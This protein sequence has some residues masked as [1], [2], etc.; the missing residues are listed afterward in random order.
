[1]ISNRLFSKISLCHLI[2]LI[3]FCFQPLL[4]KAQISNRIQLN[5]GKVTVNQSKM[6]K[7]SPVKI[8]KSD[9]Q[10]L[11]IEFAIPKFKV[12]KRT[13]NGT[14]FQIIKIP[15]FSQTSEAGKPQVPFKG[16]L[17]GIPPGT[18]AEAKILDF[19]SVIIPNYNIFPASK[20]VIKQ[21]IKKLLTDEDVN[22]EFCLDQSVY[23]NN[24]FYPHQIAKTGN[25]GFIRDQCVG[26]LQIF[27]IQFNPVTHEIRWY[28]RIKIKIS[29]IAINSN[30]K[31]PVSKI[32]VSKP[33]EKILSNSLL[34]YQA[35]KFWKR[36]SPPTHN[37]KSINRL[38]HSQIQSTWY[39]ILVEKNGIYIIDKAQLEEAGFNTSNIDPA[40]I[41]I[42][43]K[44]KEI[45]IYIKGQE[46]GV[47]DESD[48]I[49]FY[50][51]QTK[52]DYT[53]TNI[54]WLNIDETTNGLRMS[55]KDG[56]I[57]GTAPVLIRSK[58][59]IH[60]E[61]EN[62][63][64]SGI[65]NGE[66]VDHWFWDFIVAPD[67]LNF[68]ANLNNV[69]DVSNQN[70]SFK[71]EYQGFTD[72]EVS[73]DHHSILSLNGHQLL[74]DFWDGRIKFNSQTQF[75]Q[76]YLHNG[77]NTITVNLPG[78]TGADADVH[79]INWFEVEYWR[80]YIAHDDSS[81][82]WGEGSG[83]LRFEVK[84]FSNNNIEI[85]DITDITNIK[86][87]INFTV[88][89][90]DTSNTLIFQ[91]D[92]YNKQRYFALTENKR[93]VPSSIIADDPSQLQSVNN[94]ADYIIITHEDFYNYLIPLANFRQSKGLKVKIIKITDIYDEFNYGIKN[95][96][97]IKIFLNYAYCNWQKPAPTY[98]LLV[99]DATHDYKDHLKTGNK[100]YMPTHL[101]ESKEYN[102]ETS[103]D[104]WFVCVSGE[105]NLPDMLI[106][107]LSVRNESEAVT[108]VNKIIDYENNTP[109]NGWN[110]NALFIADN[111]D[112]K[113]DYGSHSDYLVENF[114]PAD[115]TACKA[116]LDD[117]L[118]ADSLKNKII[119]R[120]NQGCLIA[121]YFGHGGIEFW[122]NEK[123]L[124]S[125]DVAS[126]NNNRKL[127]FIVSLSCLNG[128][129][130]H[131]QIPYCLAEE[132][133]KA[134][135]GGAIA[136][137]SPSGFA[138]ISALQILGS[139]LF[140]SLFYNHNYTLGSI[141]ACSKIKIFSAGET[142]LDH[143]EFYNLL[144]DP[145]LRLSVIPELTI[146]PSA[147]YGN[148][149]V[150]DTLA[151]VGGV[152]SAWI[153][154]V[155]SPVNF[156]IRTPGKYGLMYINGD[157]PTTPQI[158]GGVNGDTVR[159]KLVTATQDTF[160]LTPTATWETGANHNLDLNVFTTSV[161][162]TSPISIEIQV[163]D[164]V[165]GEKILDSDPIPI[166]SIIT[167]T[168]EG[169]ENGI[170]RNKIKLLLNEQLINEDQYTYIHQEQDPLNNVVIV[171]EPQSLSYDEYE[172]IIRVSDLSPTPN[173]I[174]KHFSFKISSSLHLDRVL[175]FPNPMQNSTRFTYYLFNNEAA[176][177]NIKIYAVSG[178]LIKVINNAAGEVGYNETFWDGRDANNDE[179]ANGVYFYKITA[180]V[181]N[182]RTAVIER[183]V[184][185]K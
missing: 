47:F 83:Q 13:N 98:V 156:T 116:Y 133:L 165:V 109:E 73:P 108:I 153:N 138:N 172:M 141:V 178:R 75:P 126:L 171:Y 30:I 18:K 127:P 151:E 181:G 69:A 89:P 184:N 10:G 57:I 14:E 168:I 113:G 12:S 142:Y 48:Y 146:S 134:D 177:V 25:T 38:N 80:D 82:F 21:D 90:N 29:F 67:S 149:T 64:A 106:G 104:N 135:N 160:G 92:L 51:A 19:E 71:V 66:G 112:T 4:A 23:S 45:P 95:P 100:D 54:Y 26:N 93:K 162:L 76:S 40:K 159:F 31:S 185:M 88:E 102:T 60:F 119:Y 107:R 58:E 91:D 114:I 163:N 125:E 140:S 17:F 63:Y 124:K 174:N 145:A 41:R 120:I 28:K 35:A 27:P 61:Q 155:N 147:Y 15:G 59:N 37:F 180:K 85:F 46:D 43:N 24:N 1:M 72:L 166:N 103:S 101:F 148:I 115:F 36:T 79:Y 86:K 77:A 99:G 55:E 65:P 33:F 118:N 20:L 137:L 53:Y 136:C 170:D 32:D 22:Y 3:I 62:Y 84:N 5:N 121:N 94:Q 123:I 105:D 8:Q 143:I 164:K 183:L 161:L 139:G 97:A 179:I 173:T 111:T 176:E 74:D 150:E 9:D 52:T 152:L 132:F 68:I 50:G 157:D 169:G 110:N 131:A 182:K 16:Y 39:K 129:F 117:F 11:I 122:A 96:K 154:N 56:S 128:F 167:I 70:C 78:D 42:F 34:N 158:E 49:E 2:G 6:G 130:H 81:I 144:G 87:I 7:S 44:G 175:N